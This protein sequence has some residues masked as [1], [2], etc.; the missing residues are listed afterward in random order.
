MENRQ[1]QHQ[2][3]VSKVILSASMKADLDDFLSRIFF[4][5]VDA[6]VNSIPKNALNSSSTVVNAARWPDLSQKALCLS[7]A[8]SNS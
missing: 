3:S 7:S 4:F 8:T 1:S 5:T 2:R 6:S